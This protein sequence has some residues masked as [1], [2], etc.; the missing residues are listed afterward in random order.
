[1]IAVREFSRQHSVSSI[2]VWARENA[3]HNGQL[4][5]LLKMLKGWNMTHDT[6]LRS[7]HL[8]TMALQI[9]RGVTISSYPSGVRY[10]L[11]KARE[12]VRYKTP[13]KAGFEGNVGEYLSKLNKLFAAIDALEKAYRIA[14]D[15]EAWEACG[16]T[17]TSF[18]YWRRFFGDYFPA[19]G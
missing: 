2:Q 13:D 11:D 6:P 17:R 5:P 18:D 16:D 8:E 15:A 4:V 9:L 19:Y 10:A 14:A 7:F 1:M 3:A 12:K